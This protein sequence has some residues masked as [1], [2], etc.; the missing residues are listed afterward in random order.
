VVVVVETPVSVLVMSI[1]A[2]ASAPPWLSETV[3]EIVAVLI[4]DHDRAAAHRITHVPNNI[5]ANSEAKLLFPILPP[6]WD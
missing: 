4:C 2:S 3:P 5:L 1:F 6:G